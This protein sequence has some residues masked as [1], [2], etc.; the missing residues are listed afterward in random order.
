MNSPDTALVAL[1]WGTSSLRAYRMGPDGT[2][3]ETR[4]DGCGIQHLPVPGEDGFEAAFEAICGDW[5]AATPV[6]V[7][8]SGMVG[9]A[10]G[11][12][13]VPYLSCPA[14]TEGLAAAAVTLR[15]RGGHCVTI[16]PG[17]I[18]DGAGQ[19]PDVMRGEE[20]QIAGMLAA[21]PGLAADALMV[22]P[23][24][25]SKW[26]QMQAGQ[27]V[28]FA[29]YMT[30]EIFAVLR[31]HSILGRLMPAEAA[32]TPDD[33]AFRRGLERAREGGLTH[34]LF[35]VRTLGLTGALPPGDLPDYLSGLLIGREVLDAAAAL[36]ADR[37]LLLV[38]EGALTR[39]YALALETLLGRR[40]DAPPGNPAPAGLFR[41]AQDAGLVSRTKETSHV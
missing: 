6:P 25:H 24:T 9:S 36:D 26:A 34:A 33:A 29:T 10:Q 28:R 40:P 4:A 39:R 5:L 38:G 16:A 3:L 37:P 19:D 35:S 21:H 7:V 32:P 15:T 12:R 31:A 13:E 22:M 17:L 20:I 41:F 27:V 2:V 23:G 8:A 30:G 11:W 1:D 18:A 14:G